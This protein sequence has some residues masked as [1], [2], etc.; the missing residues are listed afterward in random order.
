MRMIR[1]GERVPP[2]RLARLE[3]DDLATYDLERLLAGRR[4]VLVGVPGAWTPTCSRQHLPDFV[5][6]APSLKRSGFDLLI[7]VSGN[8]PWV[9]RDWSKWLDPDG[10]MM[11]LSDGNLELG[12]S[13]G[14][15]QP[16]TEHYMGERLARFV[17]VTRN[18]VVERV[19]V[20][21]SSATLTCTRSQD[22]LL[23]A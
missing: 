12:R 3:D 21:P 17:L 23:A 20:E 16:L 6:N 5:A 2:I 13:A 10:E 19:N 8:D 18:A 1:T 11:F 4:A 15:V 7:C 14:L 9:M 22:V